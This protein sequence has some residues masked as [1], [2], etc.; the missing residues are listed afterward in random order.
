[1]A[2][3]HR[4]DTRADESYWRSYL[5]GFSS[6]TPLPA[7]TRAAPPKGEHSPQHMLEVGLSAEATASLQAFARQHQLT[8]HT[9][10]MAAWALVLSRYSGE[11]DVLFG[12]T[13]AG[14]PPELPG[15]EAMVGLFINSLPTRVRIPS[16]TSPLLPWLQSLQAR[17]VEQHQYEHSP[18]VQVQG[19]SQVPRGMPLFESLVVF[20]NY[21]L[22]ASVLS[23]SSL[24]VEDVRA[25][26]RTNYP[27]TL[28]VLP[29]AALRLRAVYDSPRF[30]HAAMERLLGQWR[31]ALTALV[32]PTATRLGDVSLLS[33]S[34][35]QQV[36][37]EWNQTR[38]DFPGEACIHHLFERQVALRPESIAL[39]FGEQRLSYRQLDARSNQLAHL[40]RSH[41]VGPDCL[42][43]LCLER[44]VELIVSLLAILKAGAAYLPLDASYPAE[45]LA[46]ML[47]DAPP[48]L[49]LTSRALRAQLPPSEQLPCLLVEEL[50]LEG[51]PTSTPQVAVTSRNLAYVDFTSGSTGRPK[52]VAIEHRSVLRL[53]HGIHFAHLGPEETFL[54][55]API[56]FDASTLEV[57]GPLLFGGR[58][59]VFPPHSPSDLELL[60]L[61][62][63]KHKVTTLH[64]TSGLFS[65]VVDLKLESLRGVR[66]L[67]TGGDVVSAPHVRRVLEQLHIP[68]TAC[69]GPTESTLFSSCHRMTRPEQVGASIP[70]GS[71]IANTQVYL[72]DSQML[73][74]PVGVPGELFIGGEGLARGY[75][76]RPD[77][78]A[79]R[80]VPHPFSREPG[81][82]LYRTGD[83]ARWRQDGVLEFLGRLD[84]Q[85][86]VRGFRIELAEVEGAL[87]R[88]PSV[89]EAVA[90]V[91]EDSPGHKRLVAYVVV[92]E[93]QQADTSLLRALLKQT[94]PEYMVPSAFVA[95]EALPLNSSAKVDRKALPAP[96]T[97]GAER[98]SAYVAPRDEL[99]QRLAGIW[100]QVLGIQQVGVDD[101]FFALGGDSII[102][103]QV[104]ARARQAGLAFSTRDLFQHQ[105]VA[106][107]ARVAR[108]ASAS[109]QEQGPITGPLP[110]TPIQR[111]LLQHDAAHA[112]HLNQALLLATRVPLEASLLEQTLRHLLS[113]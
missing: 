96:D 110:L 24:Q 58:L 84:N 43:A 53:F 16:A 67:L 82:R 79:E 47:E 7:D 56:S 61:V 4:R 15:A 34:E 63:S 12:N 30:E 14:R 112:H 89:R 8:A 57:W 35:R 73:P 85:V 13:V 32:A 106:Q 103:L 98:Q 22:D 36:V 95:M 33:A 55:I 111:H 48:R 113:H 60:S 2:W 9:L 49:L 74:V 1:I 25:F 3:L 62:L 88:H 44:S 54:L 6:P 46:F 105:T 66:Q 108:A 100:A 64:L 19:W 65:Q 39:E 10:A 45:R 78:T 5:E 75:L 59:V 68:V 18:L 104:V 81:A 80:F 76:S 99:E 17:Q 93:G 50:V 70:I 71:P 31:Q 26:E 37:E 91:R 21:P 27:L 97:S 11:Q 92:H 52:G 90:V 38:A 40:L 28:S 23:A 109:A 102:S 29:G 87:L 101:N 94:L 72:L 41:G 69:Y 107:L 51:Q 42:V 77:L 83:L 86:K 20:E